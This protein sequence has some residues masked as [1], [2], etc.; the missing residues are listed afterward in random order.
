MIGIDTISTAEDKISELFE[1]EIALVTLNLIA[2]ADLDGA[3]TLSPELAE[4]RCRSV[5]V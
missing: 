2:K 3:L 1:E 5:K 4:E